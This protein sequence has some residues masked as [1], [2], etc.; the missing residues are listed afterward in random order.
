[1]VV[2]PTT[3]TVP[4]WQGHSSLPGRPSSCARGRLMRNIAQETQWFQMYPTDHEAR[5]ISLK[6][7]V[8]EGPMIGF[9]SIFLNEGGVLPQPRQQSPDRARGVWLPPETGRPSA[10]REDGARPSRA[11]RIR[12]PAGSP[13]SMHWTDAMNEE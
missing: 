3:G 11:S 13:R 10:R 8:A 6:E 12:E 9:F 7:P 1:M 4:S 5:G 2:S